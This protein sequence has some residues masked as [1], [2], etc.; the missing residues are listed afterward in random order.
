MALENFEKGAILNAPGDSY[1]GI[2]MIRRAVA[3]NNG[4]AGTENVE[5]REG[6]ASGTV[7]VRINSL[8]E[9]QETEIPELAGAEVR[10]LHASVLT[11]P[12]RV[13]LYLR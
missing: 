3:F 8:D 2:A 12:A 5:L 11:S 13:I 7:L 9:Q 4:G 10:D 6:G 1:P